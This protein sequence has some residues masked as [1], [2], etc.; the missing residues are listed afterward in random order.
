MNLQNKDFVNKKQKLFE[1]SPKLT[2]QTLIIGGQEFTFE[3]PA[4]VTVK[5]K[6]NE[7]IEDKNTLNLINNLGL[8]RKV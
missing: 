5:I 8:H 6:S 1:L 7:E 3:K 2:S 4:G